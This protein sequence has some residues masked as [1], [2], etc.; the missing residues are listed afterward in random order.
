[1]GDDGRC[2]VFVLCAV[3][4][5]SCDL[6]ESASR[7]LQLQLRS[8]LCAAASLEDQLTGLER[9]L[10]YSYNWQTFEICTRDS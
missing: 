8:L 4:C 3:L 6:D 10:W 5:A 9:V 7:Q 1:M 2:D